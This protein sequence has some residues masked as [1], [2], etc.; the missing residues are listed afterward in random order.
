MIN[1]AKLLIFLGIILFFIGGILLF[2]GEA[3]LESQT[4]DILFSASESISGFQFSI[5]SDVRNPAFGYKDISCQSIRNTRSKR[6]K[7]EYTIVRL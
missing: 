4:I 1:I 6:S 7:Y 3:D 2:F 5:S